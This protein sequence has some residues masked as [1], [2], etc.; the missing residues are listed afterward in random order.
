MD[1]QTRFSSIQKQAVLSAILSHITKAKKQHCS[2]E[3]I[4]HVF[5]EVQD[6]VLPKAKT[7][8]EDKWTVVEKWI[9]PGIDVYRG[10]H[11]AENKELRAIITDLNKKLTEVALVNNS[12]DS[13]IQRVEAENRNLRKQ[14][15]EKQTPPKKHR[16]KVVIAGLLHSQE[17]IIKSRH[18]EA[19]NLSFV[20]SDQYSNG[21]MMKRME[22]CDRLVIMTDFVSHNSTQATLKDKV[23]LVKGGMSSLHRALSDLLI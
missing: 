7:I 1:K 19:F 2:N 12:L 18:C 4:K 8:D 16:P 11:N 17:Q 6:S 9:I 10:M 21:Q 22:N 13:M 14:L 23:T 5:F 15:S 20:T 3:Y